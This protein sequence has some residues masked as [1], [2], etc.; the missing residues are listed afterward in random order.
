MMYDIQSHGVRFKAGLAF[1]RAGQGE[2]SASSSSKVLEPTFNKEKY[3][4]NKVLNREH[5]CIITTTTYIHLYI[6]INNISSIS[7]CII[8]CS[9]LSVAVIEID[10]GYGGLIGQNEEPI[11][12]EN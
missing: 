3:F 9:C 8:S 10:C 6:L 11:T 5:K 12:E 7:N 1:P 2:H 4:E